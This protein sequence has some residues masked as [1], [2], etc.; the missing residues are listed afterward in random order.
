MSSRGDQRPPFMT[1]CCP[2]LEW[3][4]SRKSRAVCPL[5]QI[6]AIGAKFRN[7]DERVFLLE[8][9]GDDSKPGMGVV[10]RELT[11]SFGTFD[12]DLL[13]VGSLIE[14]Q[15]RNCRRHRGR[16]GVSCTEQVRH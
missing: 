12:E 15:L 16:E 10:E 5:D 1:S 11:F 3:R 2:S 9:L 4:Y 14:G 8:L 6:P 7:F 13:A